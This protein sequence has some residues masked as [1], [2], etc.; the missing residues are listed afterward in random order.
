MT[1]L[2]EEIQAAC[3][4]EE[5]ASKEHGLIAAK[6][7]VGRKRP[8][9]TA[10]GEGTILAVLGTDAGNAFLD[11]ID[12]V[13]DFRHVKKIVARGDFDVSTLASQAGI[14]AMVPTVLTQ[15]QADA[16]KALGVAPA[17]V[18]VH[19]VITALGD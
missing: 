2:L 1:T 8:Q 18:S 7:S 11:V 10:I 12:T 3:T 13:P 17:P 19:E 16:L 4:A 14:Q 9:K 5:I 6:V 15:E